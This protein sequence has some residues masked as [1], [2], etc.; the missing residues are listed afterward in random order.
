M[1]G[2]NRRVLWVPGGQ[3]HSRREEAGAGPVAEFRILPTGRRQRTR[4]AAVRGGDTW[5]DSMPR[6]NVAH[7]RSG[8][9]T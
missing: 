6:F 9:H 3:D 1:S 2:G 8:E 4:T 7:D 5:P